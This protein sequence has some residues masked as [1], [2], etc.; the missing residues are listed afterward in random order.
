MEIRKKIVKIVKEISGAKKVSLD[1]LLKKDLAI[2]SLGMVNIILS[3][4]EELGIEL[5]EADLDPS[6][7]NKVSDIYIKAKDSLSLFLYILRY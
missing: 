4:E 3:I 2:D 7:L 5:D 6:L 1:S